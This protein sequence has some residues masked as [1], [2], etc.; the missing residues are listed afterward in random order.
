M[1]ELVQTSEK[2]ILFTPCQI[3][4]KDL[5]QNAAP[6]A[7]VWPEL[8]LECLPNRD[9]ILYEDVYGIKGVPTIFRGTLRYDGFSSLMYVFRNV[10]LF[11]PQLF[12]SDSIWS[13]VLD[14]LRRIS[15]NTTNLEDFFVHCAGGDRQLAGRAWDCLQWMNMTSDNDIVQHSG[16]VIDLFCEKLEKYLQYEKDERDMVAMHHAISATFDDGSI[17]E[18]NSTLLTI[19]T[20]SM[21]AMCRTVG[22]PTAAT[23]DLILRGQLPGRRGLVLPTSKDIYK[24]TLE[25]MAKEGIFFQER[26]RVT[27][28]KQSDAVQL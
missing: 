5:L 27:M 17:E 15:G 16:P 10:G 19:G 24:P 9:S 6:F 7:E 28:D 13:N 22:Y 25:M 3:E 26:V 20:E 4:G 2:C 1:I 21:T 18:H 8:Q 23:T 12:D 14:E 11:G